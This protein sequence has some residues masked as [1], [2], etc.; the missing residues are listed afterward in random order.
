MVNHYRSKPLSRRA[1]NIIEGLLFL[2]VIPAKAG[3]HLSAGALVE[4]WI[5]SGACARARLRR[6]PGDGMTFS[7]IDKMFFS[8]R[9]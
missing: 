6:D 8:D 9:F 7:M 1:F 5:P 3:I 2:A 4:T